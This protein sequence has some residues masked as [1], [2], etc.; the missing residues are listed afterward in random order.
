MASYY[1]LVASLPSL[2]YEGS[3]PF[4]TESFLKLCTNQLSDTHFAMVRAVLLG[5]P[6][7]HRFVHSY[8]HFASM[9]KK[10]L[11]EQRS[12]KLSLSDSSYKNDGDREAHIA[13]VV[14]QALSMEDVLAAE[15]LLV[16]LHWNFID[17]LCAL[18]TFDIEAVLGYAIK[19][20]MLERKSLF[21]REEG[22]AEF[23]RLFSNIQ[24]EI[25][26]N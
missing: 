26:N 9:V 18:H 25:E 16:Q 3:L 2:R 6:C 12:R 1:Y 19:L 7:S 10:E 22:N 21:T 23:K 17:E 15:M 5:Q 24:T 14:R 8:E 20:R 4:T 13:D 11:T